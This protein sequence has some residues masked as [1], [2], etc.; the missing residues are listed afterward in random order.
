MGCS[1]ST[2]HG[3]HGLRS[4][5]SAW[6]DD[7][8]AEGRVASSASQDLIEQLGPVT[9]DSISGSFYVLVG[10]M[11]FGMRVRYAGRAVEFCL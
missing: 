2:S 3:K 11:Q 1:L 5:C 8:A 10:A 6:R 7:Q 4:K 9:A